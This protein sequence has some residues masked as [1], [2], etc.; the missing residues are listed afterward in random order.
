MRWTPDPRGLALALALAI[1]ALPASAGAKKYQMASTWF[2]RNGD[3]FIPL[4][5]TAY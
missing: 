5:G 2:I 1:V 3:V 4:Q